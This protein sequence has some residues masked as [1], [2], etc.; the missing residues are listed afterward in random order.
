MSKPVVV[1]CSGCRQRLGYAEYDKSLRNA[2]FCS[3]WCLNQPAITDQEARNEFWKGL[4]FQGMSP[5]RISKVYNVAHSL[6]YRSV[7]RG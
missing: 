1:R 6:V 3:E 2:V 4:A 7:G 5:Y